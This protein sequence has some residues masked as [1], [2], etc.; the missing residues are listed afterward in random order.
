MNWIPL[1]LK[2]EFSDPNSEDKKDNRPYTLWIKYWGKINMHWVL[3]WT[4]VYYENDLQ[5]SGI[6]TWSRGNI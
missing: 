6:E 3:D 5:A 2:H 1:D 4:A